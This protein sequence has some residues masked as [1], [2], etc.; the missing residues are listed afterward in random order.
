MNQ[1]DYTLSRPVSLSLPVEDIDRLLAERDGSAALVYLALQRTGGMPLNPEALGMTEKQ[2]TDALITLERLG[3]VK[4]QE[5]PKKEPPLPPADELP[6][7]TAE[8]LIRR[9]NEDADF[10]GV[11]QHA[12]QLYGRKLSTPETQS[13]LG[14][15]D[16]L[17]LPPEVLM[18]LITYVFDRYR[19][20]HGPGRAPT[21]HMI[22]AEAYT[23]ARNELLTSEL[24]QEY[25]LRQQ[26]RA[27]KTIQM[28]EALSLCGRAPSKTEQ[29][30]IAGWLEMGFGTDAVAEAYDRTVTSTGTLK[31]QYLNKILVNWDKRGLHRLADILENDP[32]GSGG[33]R[34]NAPQPADAKPRDDLALAEK[35]IR[36]RGKKEE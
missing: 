22:E 23:W 34:K 1:N 35:L 11:L 2:Y 10:R 6:Q 13:L 28:M 14:M 36:G 25:I 5:P 24:A 19:K 3:V 33:R 7:Y 4:G 9:T 31:W 20:A 15:Q 16:Y 32:R 18:E 12:E 26:R 29:K 30:Y 21:M 27:D 8:D 17:G